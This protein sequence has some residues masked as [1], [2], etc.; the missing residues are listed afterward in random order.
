M[1]QS[2]DLAR[3]TPVAV[4]LDGAEPSVDW[5]DM[6][7][8]RFTDPFF[9][10]SVARFMSSGKGRS[11]VRTPLS[12]L[13]DL[14]QARSLDPCGFIFHVGRC[15]STLV[16]RLLGLVPGVIAVREPRPINNLLEADLER[17]DEAEQ[18]RLLRS[19]IRALGRVRFGDERHFVLK[20]SSWNI[21]KAALFREAFPKVPMVWL[22]RRPLEVLA[23]MFVD[24]PGWL[25]L[26]NQPAKAAQFFGLDPAAVIRM[27]GFEFAAQ[28]LASMF[29]AATEFDLE[30]V[31]YDDLPRAVTDVVAPLFGITF[32]A[33]D[34]L[35]MEE[36]AR[37]HA[38]S[39]NAV[40]FSDDSERK[41]S[42]PERAVAVSSAL[43]DPRYGLLNDRR[44]AQRQA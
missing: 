40:P 22:Q 23:S 34:R 24:P 32:S 7:G 25:A 42:A 14:D 35:L 16:S 20:L 1:P 29:D 28:L 19:L 38:K 4:N 21:R 41:R 27:D 26:R 31:D 36:Q 8:E 10:Q 18:V 12:A 15:G 13:H 30:I 2:P 43:L 44:L 9:D 33:A 6:S 3:W 5:C 11:I 37:Y 17:L 39:A